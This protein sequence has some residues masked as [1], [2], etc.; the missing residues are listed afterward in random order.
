MP[1]Y[2]TKKNIQ[3]LPIAERV[4]YDFVKATTLTD[5][6]ALTFFNKIMNYMLNLL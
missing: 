3:G 2:S 5:L 4:N 1:I 6:L